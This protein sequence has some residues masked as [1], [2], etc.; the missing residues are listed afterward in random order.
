MASPRWSQSLKGSSSVSGVGD[1]ECRHSKVERP[2][3]GLARALA[4]GL[5]DAGER[6]IF[7]PGGRPR[8]E[9]I[10]AAARVGIHFVL[11]DTQTAAHMM[12]ASYGPLTHTPGVAI[13]SRGRACTNSANGLA[14]ATPDRFPLLL[15]TDPV[16]PAS[17]GHTAH[18]R[19]DQV[20]AAAPPAKSSG[21]LGTPDP[22]CVVQGCA[23]LALRAPAGAVRL[24]RPGRHRARGRAGSGR[25]DARPVALRR[26]D[27]AGTRPPDRDRLLRYAAPG[28][29]PLRH[30]AAGAWAG[31]RR[32]R[33]GAPRPGRR[34]VPR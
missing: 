10:A 12:A 1:R 3:A 33:D 2:L 13:V 6:T 8:L 31:A 28:H 9:M 15:V 32:D 24:F 27:R 22:A 11:V 14:Q 7:G 19:L 18:Q 5:R 23:Q 29:R 25:A 30:R 34:L 21:T 20:A 26:R 17:A 4:A 16:A